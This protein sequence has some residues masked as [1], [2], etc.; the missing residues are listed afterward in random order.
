MRIRTA[1]REGTD[2]SALEPRRA[3]RDRASPVVNPSALDSSW[4]STSAVDVTCH[5]TT[6]A[7]EVVT[8]SASC[9]LRRDR[10]ICRLLH[11]GVRVALRLQW[12]LHYS[13][14]H[15]VTTHYVHCLTATDATQMGG[16]LSGK[17]RYRTA[18]PA[19]D[20]D[21]ISQRCAPSTLSVTHSCASLHPCWPSWC[22]SSACTRPFAPSVWILRWS[23]HGL[24]ARRLPFR[25]PGGARS[26][27]PCTE[28]RKG[29]RH[30][31]WPVWPDD[32]LRGG[33][34]CKRASVARLEGADV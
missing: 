21:S 17:H 12:R 27:W 24:V 25:G 13:A 15:T 23:A 30:S 22:R 33:S 2:G 8:L 10:P 3:S 18:H 6:S 19:R 9:G 4:T 20:C 5:G 34:T 29:I 28:D 32:S 16:R 31:R 7:T 11:D 14:D 26:C 1:L